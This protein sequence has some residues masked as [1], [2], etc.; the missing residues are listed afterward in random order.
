MLEKSVSKQRCLSQLSMQKTEHIKLAAIPDARKLM[1]DN[2]AKV[3]RVWLAFTKFVKHQL[4]QGKAVDT[5]CVG[6]FL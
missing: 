5:N 4:A 1:A 2:T 3:H 6:V